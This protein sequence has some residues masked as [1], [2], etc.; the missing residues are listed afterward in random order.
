MTK[1]KG[2]F[3]VDLDGTLLTSRRQLAREDLKALCRLREM[4]YLIAIATGR[5][6][7]SF[8]QLIS[9][10]GYSKAGERLPVDYV[11]F[12]TGAGI[13]DFPG[14]TILN[15]STLNLPDIRCTIEYLDASGLDYMIHRAVP[16][17]R[18]FLYRTT[19][20][21]NPDFHR[22]LE[23]YADF[24]TP[25]SPENLN[26]FGGA[27]EVLCIVPDP[28]GHEVANSIADTLKQ[29]S[30][31]K[32]TSPLDG[33][34]IWIE[35]F[36]QTVSKSQAAQWLADAVGLSRHRICAVGNDYNDLDLL[37]WAGQSF[38]VTNGPP[39]LKGMF[40]TVASNDNGGVSEAVNRWLT[41]GK[42]S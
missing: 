17:T 31:I 39:S 29:C 33:K 30:V 11:I 20:G 1:Y 9:N 13:M 2:L 38:L 40:Q 10:L 4:N 37:H 5:S 12:S 35:V 42:N 25:L 18:H 19:G 6:N 22:R 23:M 28:G 26:N 7:Y 21:D 14:Y 16:D 36:A 15:S 3:I 8:T 27:T 41:T 24:A 32:A 34:S